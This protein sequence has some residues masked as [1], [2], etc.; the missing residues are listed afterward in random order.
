MNAPPGDFT[1]AEFIDVSIYFN[2]KDYAQEDLSFV[3]NDFDFKAEAYKGHFPTKEDE[4]VLDAE[5]CKKYGSKYHFRPNVP[6]WMDLGQN[7]AKS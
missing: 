5:A 1:T 3:N 2:P 6:I 4:P 7:F